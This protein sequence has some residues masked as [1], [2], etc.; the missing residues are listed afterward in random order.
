[1]GIGQ[2]ELVEVIPNNFGLVCPPL[3]PSNGIV[4]LFEGGNKKFEEPNEEDDDEDDDEVELDE[5]EEE[6]EKEEDEDEVL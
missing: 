2:F 6:V 1:M 3:V 4:G 5:D